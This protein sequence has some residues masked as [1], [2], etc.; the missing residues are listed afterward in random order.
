MYLKKIELVGFKSFANKTVVDFMPDEPAN[1]KNGSFESENNKRRFAG[2]TAIVGPNGSGKSNIADAIRWAMG[3]QSMKNLRGKKMEDII[4]AGSGKRGRLN[5]A[6]VSLH[7]DNSDKQIPLDFSE[8]IIKRKL[9]RNG[10]SEY[11]INGSR[12][13]LI[14]VADLLAKAGVGKDSYSV[15]NQGMSDAILNAS[16]SERRE[17][18]EDAAGVKQYQIKKNRALRK[19]ETT[20]K[21][22]IQV[23]GLLNEINPHLQSLRRQAN[24]AQKGGELKI[25]LRKLQEKYFAYLWYKFQQEQ[26]KSFDQKETLGNEM[27][28]LQ[29][30]VDKLNDLVLVESRKMRQSK[31]PDELRTKKDKIYQDMNKLERERM[32]VSGK[33][34]IT[35]EKIKQQNVIQNIPVDKRYIQLELVQLHNEQKKLIEKI[36]NVEKLEELQDIREFARVIEQKTFELRN[37]IE[38][39]NVE[40]RKTAEQIVGEK[41]L[42]KLISELEKQQNIIIQK[43]VILK[44]QILKINKEI[45][46]EIRKDEKDRENFFQKEDDLR[47]K[48]RKLNFLKDKFNEAKIA[49]ARIEVREEDLTEDAKNDLGIKIQDLKYDEQKINVSDVEQKIFTI[50]NRLDQIGGIDPLIMDEYQETNQRYE[51]LQQESA[52]LEKAIVSLKEIAKEM[53]KKIDKVFTTAFSKINKE[54]SKYFRIIFGGGNA[55]LIKTKN[56]KKKM[57]NIMNTNEIFNEGRS[58]MVEKNNVEIDDNE[59]KSNNDNIAGEMISEIGV[60]ISACPPGKKIS[61]LTMLSG[62]ERSLTALALLFAIISYN[63]PPFAVLDEVEAALDEANSLRFG[64]I[65]QELSNNTQ[66]IAITHNRETMHQA[67]YLYGATMG[68]DGVT[69]LLSVKLDKYK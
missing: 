21:N 11:V 34:E 68:D 9:F 46:I 47:E 41:K 56:L 60:D 26:K 39:G 40:G 1:V 53:D 44:E 32:V 67:S 48:Q 22:L 54:F 13:R 55:T 69:K 5:Y 25:K 45:E 14:D 4:F 15:L 18:F 30:D 38:K 36:K 51:T 59:N 64:K 19:I 58:A 66:F 8:V 57:R 27:M 50:K 10:D 31:K 6:T 16:P 61:N 49:L 42:K 28:H 29:K 35:Q 43:I 33:L 63:P 52:D 23:E 17:I 62:G 3:E 12:V 7:F 20:H 65:L 37:D 24:K 2:I